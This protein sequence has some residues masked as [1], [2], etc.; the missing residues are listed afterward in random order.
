MKTLKTTLIAFTF[1]ALT[2]CNK[3][4]NDNTT[5]PQPAVSGQITTLAGTGAAGNVNGP[6][7]TAQ[8][9]DLLGVCV[10]SNGN[11][12]VVDR[13]YHCIKKITPAGVVS[14]FAGSA[15]GD[16]GN[17][18]SSVGSNAKFN[19]PNGICIDTNNNL[20]VADAYNHCI[21]KITPSGAVSTFCGQKGTRANDDN[22]GVL[23]G[24]S[25]PEGICIDNQNNLYVAEAG[26][27][28]VRKITPAGVVTTLAGVSLSPPFSSYTT[29]HADGVGSAARFGT[30]MGGITTDNAGN[31]YVGE[32]GVYFSIR[33]IEIASKNVT[34]IAGNGEIDAL[35]VEDDGVGINCKAGPDGMCFDGQGNIMFTS[36]GSVRKLSLSDA[37]VTTITRNPNQNKPDGNLNDSGF[38]FVS[39]I[40]YR[41]GK[42]YVTEDRKVRILTLN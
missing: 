10:D 27:G 17:T 35:G 37:K 39:Q 19:F 33:K 22:T 9:S 23:A 13:E 12:F 7:A 26:V 20:F 24:F 14:L 32:G 29:S 36:Y 40:A 16:I 21:R 30:L 6:G 4:N 8:F 42:F 11:V 2:S 28:R 41:N 5:N 1:F 3:S 25:D 34:T 18:D 38:T 31:I 15:T